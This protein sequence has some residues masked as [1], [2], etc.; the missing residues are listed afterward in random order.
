MSYGKC[1]I[2]E[3]TVHGY[4]IIVGSYGSKLSMSSLIPTW[5]QCINEPKLDQ[6][7]GVPTAQLICVF[8]FAYADCLISCRD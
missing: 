7:L 8:V 5:L 6:Q 2:S 1:G 4:D 3:Y